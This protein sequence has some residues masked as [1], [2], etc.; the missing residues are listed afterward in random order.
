MAQKIEKEQ[1]EKIVKNSLSKAEVIKKLGGKGTEGGWYRTVNKYI[2]LWEVDTSHFL[3]QGWNKGQKF[4]PN[5]FRRTPLKNLLIKN[6]SCVN[7]SHLKNRLVKEGLL[8][9][10]CDCCSN[11]G[12][13][14]GKKLTL[15]L[16]HINGVSND[17]R[18]ENLRLLCPNCHAQTKTYCRSN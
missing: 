18:I 11:D 17:N 1:F 14:Q 12:N 5:Q 16:D 8:E 7:T 4:D 6:S 10:R 2:N 3:G 9:Y 13:W 15:Q